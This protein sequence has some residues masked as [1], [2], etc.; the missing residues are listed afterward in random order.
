MTASTSC[1][2]LGM[3]ASTSC[4]PL[5]MTAYTSCFP[6]GMTASLSCLLLG[7]QVLLWPQQ[8]VSDK[9]TQNAIR[10]LPCNLRGLC[11]HEE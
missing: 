7:M 3:T 9:H 11:G 5:G 1:F 6:L 10:W 8:K 4:F 2:P